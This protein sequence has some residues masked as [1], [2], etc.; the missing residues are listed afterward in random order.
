MKTKF[1]CFVAVAVLGAAALHAQPPA[2]S[3]DQA[4]VYIPPAPP[5]PVVA[6]PLPL[7]PPPPS[8][9]YAA[10]AFSPPTTRLA[11]SITLPYAFNWNAAGVSAELGGLWLGSHFFGGEVSYYDGDAQDYQ[12][13][14]GN[15]AYVGH[16]RSSR[17][18]TT[19][20]FAYRY[21]APLWQFAPQSPVGFYLGAS[22]GAGFVSYSDTGGAFG[23]RSQNDRGSFSGELDAGLQ[24]SAGPGAS[25]R[26]GWR[27]VTLSDVPNFNRHSDLDS[28]VLEAGL[29]FRF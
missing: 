15:G 24:F 7:P 12:V 4:S 6:E 27:Y 1:R 2:A 19:V 14:N 17:Q 8:P 26:L 13:F 28:S 10:S 16:F 22:G 23:F 21:F 11:G 9:P 5:A 18:I 29:A 25:L 20:D 3:S